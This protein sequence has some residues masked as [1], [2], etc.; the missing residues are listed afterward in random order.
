[1]SLVEADDVPEARSFC[2]TRRTRKPRPAASRAMPVP[3]IPP[4]TIARSK[5]DMSPLGAWQ[6]LPRFAA[7][8]TLH[9]QCPTKR[10]ASGAASAKMLPP[11]I[12]G[13]S[14]GLSRSS[15][16]RHGR[17]WGTG[18]RRGGR[19]HGGRRDLPCAL[20]GGGRGGAFS[21][22]GS[23][24]GRVAGRDRSYGRNRGRGAL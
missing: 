15:C 2:S 17:D 14:R 6:V 20:C 3:L 16:D 19:P 22:A 18:G 8:P 10:L 12:Q 13:G 7:C 5:S 11:I 23:S 4:P 21:L 1:M 24:Q 9:S